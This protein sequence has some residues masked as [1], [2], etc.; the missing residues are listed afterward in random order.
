MAQTKKQKPS[1]P[2]VTITSASI[3]AIAEAVADAMEAKLAAIGPALAR[4][5]AANTLQ[6]VERPET[7]FKR[8]LDEGDIVRG[9]I[10]KRNTRG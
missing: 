5:A 10:V 3:R 7:I 4:L 9:L 6:S 2:E 8:A 1:T